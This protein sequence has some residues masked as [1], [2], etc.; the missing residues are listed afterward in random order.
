[1]TRGDHITITPA[2]DHGEDSYKVWIPPSNANHYDA[3]GHPIMPFGTCFFSSYL[4][5]IDFLRKAEDE[6]IR[7]SWEPKHRQ[8]HEV[9]RAAV[10]QPCGELFATVVAPATNL[11]PH[12]IESAGASNGHY[13]Y[14]AACDAC[15]ADWDQ[16]APIPIIGLPRH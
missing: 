3:N 13:T 5:A 6:L 1:M 8:A 7:T 16:D 2:P 14:V 15:T 4:L 12:Q 10:C 11:V 9:L